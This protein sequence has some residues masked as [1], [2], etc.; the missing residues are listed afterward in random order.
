M[1]N[2]EAIFNT[3]YYEYHAEVYDFVQKKV[4]CSYLAEEVVQLTFIK[5]WNNRKKIPEHIEL[6]TQVFQIAKTVLIDQLRKK[7]SKKNSVYR[8]P[9]AD[10][11]YEPVNHDVANKV[12]FNDTRA[13]IE[14]LLNTLPPVRKKVFE[15]S[16]FDEL[17]H[18]E[19]SNLLNISIKTVESHITHALKHI[20]LYWYMVLLLA[21][22]VCL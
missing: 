14:K 12:N 19:I 3:V 15:L 5:F 18:K 21:L 17:S 7:Y 8:A 2:P 1:H 4:G 20:K 13:R 22:S 10:R 11:A 6:R 16:R 9:Q